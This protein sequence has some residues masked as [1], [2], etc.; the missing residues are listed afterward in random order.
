LIDNEPENQL[1]WEA[2]M[3]SIK[4][5]M[6]E[7][8]CE[9]CGFYPYQFVCPL[10]Q[11]YDTGLGDCRPYQMDVEPEEELDEKMVE[12]LCEKLDEEMKSEPESAQPAFREGS[13]EACQRDWNDGMNCVLCCNIWQCLFTSSVACMLM[14]LN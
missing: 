13:W 14:I 12:E 5:L 11:G 10:L 9:T 6:P 2:Y 7:L 8:T 4:H 3:A 1:G